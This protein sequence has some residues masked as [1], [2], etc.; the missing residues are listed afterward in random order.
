VI[1]TDLPITASNHILNLQIISARKENEFLAELKSGSSS[2]FSK[3]YGNYSAAL[4]GIIFRIV[5]FQEPAEDVLQETFIKIASKIS[6]FD[7][8]KERIFTWM[9]G[10]RPILQ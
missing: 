7:P 5:K 10:L 8:A 4:M 1:I 6:R 3:L 9:P 2:A